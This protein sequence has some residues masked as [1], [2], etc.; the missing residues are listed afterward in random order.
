MKLVTLFLSLILSASFAFAAQKSGEKRKRYRKARIQNIV[1][2]APVYSLKE[3]IHFI[4]LNT[5]NINVITTNDGDSKENGFWISTGR[6]L[7][8]FLDEHRQNGDK[9]RYDRFTCKG[10]EQAGILKCR[11][12]VVENLKKGEMGLTAYIF[13]I[14]KDD[15]G[16]LVRMLPPIRPELMSGVDSGSNIAILEY[17]SPERNPVE[18]R[19]FRN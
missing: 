17:L 1:E 3:I 15:Q 11:L 7:N 14:S 12:I 5:Q 18:F 9:V 13:K 4:A 8:S 6:T 19:E 2:S 16:G 10:T